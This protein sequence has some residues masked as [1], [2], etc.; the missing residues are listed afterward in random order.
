MIFFS[1]F[2]TIRSKS[3]LA[4]GLPGTIAGSPSLRFAVA[5][6]KRSSRNSALRA[7]ASMPWHA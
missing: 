2:D 1:S 6:S 7:A 3:G 4:S 5:D